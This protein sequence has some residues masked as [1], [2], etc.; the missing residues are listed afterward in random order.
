MADVYSA[1]SRSGYV[2][3]ES[4]GLQIVVC[5]LRNIIAS[6]FFEKQIQWQKRACF[7]ACHTKPLPR[8]GPQGGG[9][10]YIICIS[11]RIGG[12]AISAGVKLENPRAA[13]T[14]FEGLPVHLSANAFLPVVSDFAAIRVHTD[15]KSGKPAEKVVYPARQ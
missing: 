9:R 8:L 3:I 15:P 4:S 12:T 6:R 7:S 13:I 14:A 5:G 2:G 1:H 10:V 11:P